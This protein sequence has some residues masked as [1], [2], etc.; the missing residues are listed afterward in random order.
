LA[1]AGPPLIAMLS[2]LFA[3]SDA[4]G[5][6]V[7]PGAG[8]VAEPA[9]PLGTIFGRRLHEWAVCGKPSCLAF[10]AVN[11]MGAGARPLFCICPV[12]PWSIFA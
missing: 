4:L 1:S 5:Q 12:C 10:P 11:G 2:S 8:E 6:S 9:V 3:R 7:I